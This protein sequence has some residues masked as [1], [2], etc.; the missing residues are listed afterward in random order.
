MTPV[1]VDVRLLDPERWTALP[2]LPALPAPPAAPTRLRLRAPET[3]SLYRLA[4]DTPW[5]RTTLQRAR[6]LRQLLLRPP[7]NRWR[8]RAL[9]RALFTPL[10]GVEGLQVALLLM[11]K[12][13]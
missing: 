1:P 5:K 2:L 7:A 6:R 9:F 13:M 4:R 10:S 12:A 3:S 8:R 11:T